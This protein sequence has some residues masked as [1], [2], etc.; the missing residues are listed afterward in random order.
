M[1]LNNCTNSEL[2]YSWKETLNASN[3]A[4]E[5][6]YIYVSLEDSSRRMACLLELHNSVP[7]NIKNR[8]GL[9]Y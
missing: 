4:I 6:L 1:S 8:R 9:R 7:H 3:Q 5:K 2:E